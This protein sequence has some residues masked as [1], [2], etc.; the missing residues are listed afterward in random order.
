MKKHQTIEE[1]I[2]AKVQI[3]NISCERRSF[4]IQQI[5]EFFVKNGYSISNRYK[6]IDSNA[7]LILLTSCGRTKYS[8]DRTFETY[9]LIKKKKKP[10]AKIILGGCLTEINPERLSKEFDGPSFSFHSL[11]KLDQMINA[12]YKC[13]DCKR[14]NTFVSNLLKVSTITCLQQ[15][16]DVFKQFD[17]N[18]SGLRNILYR[19]KNGIEIRQNLNQRTYFIQV[20]Q[21]CSESCSY[22]VTRKAIG[23][24]RSKPIKAIIDEFKEGLENGFEHFQLCG[25]NVGSY[26]LDLGI[27]LSHLLDSI[28]ETQEKFDLNLENIPPVNFLQNFNSIRNLATQNRLY[29]LYI[30]IQ[31]A[32]KRLLTLMNRDSDIDTVKKMVVEIKKVGSFK[33]GTTLLIGFP[34]ETIPELNETIRFCNEIGFDWI[35]CHRFSARPGTPAALME[36]I[37]ADEILRRAHYVKSQLI[38]KSF[39]YFPEKLPKRT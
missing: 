31:S 29:G 19:M 15:T 39:I 23:R 30:P 21:G 36:Q 8:E 26:G 2:M 11:S 1:I 28:S 32:N 20:A 3:L 37:P 7:D 38:N 34:S 18:L 33:I 12:K 35:V 16:S 17:G 6:D 25:D 27:N 10:E 24:L 9:H 4:E 5:K 14:P 13:R 22:C